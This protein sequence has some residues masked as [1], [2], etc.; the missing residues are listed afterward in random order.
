VATPTAT[1][2]SV[3]T[4]DPGVTGADEAT[5][6][7][8]A[9]G[10]V[11]TMWTADDATESS[12]AFVS[13][14]LPAG[15]YPYFG[16]WDDETAGTF[17]GGGALASFTLADDGSV[18]L[19][20][21]AV[22]NGDDTFT[23]SVAVIDTTVWPAAEVEP[24]V[25][26]VP[27]N[28]TTA[29]NQAR[30][31][32]KIIDTP[33][34]R[35]PSYAQATSRTASIDTP[36]DRLVV[37]GADLTFVDGV[38]AILEGY[39]LIDPLLYGSATVVI[40]A[41]NPLFG[42]P[43]FGANATE[44]RDYFNRARVR[45]DR[46][47]AGEVSARDFKGFV[48]RVDCDDT[49]LRLEVA[50]EA[51]GALSMMYVPSPVYRRKQDVEHILVDLLRDARVNAHE[52][53]GA[54]GVGLIRRG[55][56][57]GLTIFN[58]TLAVWAGATGSPI[59]FTP[60]SDGDYRKTVKPDD[61]DPVDFT[62]Y[63]SDLVSVSLAQDFTEQYDRVYAHGFTP[64]GELVTNVKVPGITQGTPPS[65]PGT[66][67]PGDTGDDVIVIQYQ[68][69]LHNFLDLED[70][71]I[72]DFDDATVDAVLA[73]KRDAGLSSL[74]PEVGSPAWDALWDLASLGYTL[75][76]AREYPMVQDPRTRKWNRSANGSRIEENPDYDQTYV[77]NDIFFDAS[78]P[79]T[80]TQIRD[81]ATSKLV[82]TDGVWTGTITLRSGLWVGDVAPGDAVSSALVADRRDVLPNARI[83]IPWFGGDEAGI[84]VYVS[85][86][87]HGPDQSQLL[88]ST[89]PTTTME[90]WQ[91][92]ERRREAKSNPGRAWSGHVRA[93]Q[94]RNDRDRQWDTTGGRIGND[95]DLVSG[96]NE[97]QVPVGQAGI[98]Q[99]VHT[100]LETPAEYALMI[101]RRPVDVD[102][103]NGNTHT[104]TPLVDPRPAN[105]P[106]WEQTT[107]VDWL[108][109]RG[110]LDAWGTPKQPC[111]YDP[112]LKTD[113]N[114]DTAAPLTGEF[115]ET[116]GLNY[117]THVEPVLYLYIWVGSANT[118][119]K[120]RI[121]YKQ[122]TRDF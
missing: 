25:E 98:V 70:C 22:D 20:L 33:E 49:V 30:I 51:S 61:G 121:P 66:V 69:A 73:F 102:D 13:I 38:P 19:D 45:L 18:T 82:G 5:G 36:L 103:L 92:I 90:T 34:V 2:I 68:L 47:V 59:T 114:G 9:Y 29:A 7:T 23:Y 91:A 116:A 37:N 72:G 122:D 83:R 12:G 115:K 64:Q 110:L 77:P 119:K 105:R 11:Q 52:H 99:I 95:V 84:V 35:L 24:D 39:K 3:H 71:T 50:G 48:T 76:D 41:I 108:N 86:C 113:E 60:N 40:P 56:A 8:P 94:V 78:G 15:T 44:L 118:L 74:T 89:A 31:V 57:D 21:S 1:W 55:E 6:G 96:W 81:F 75:D 117:E 16:V 104:A 43:D 17:D 93:S 107:V 10:R 120:G 54:S 109:G 53:A 58:E 97:I 46:V 79:F 32:A 80:K 111:G 101:T 27:S 112:S 62:A 67:N 88:V 63:P 100:Q 28:L 85:G 14:N 26:P 87:D 4:A 65:F 106:W 42:H